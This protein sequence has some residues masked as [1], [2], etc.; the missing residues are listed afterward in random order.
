MKTLLI[1]GNGNISWH[2]VQKALEAGHEVWELNRALTRKTRRGVQPEV[3]QIIG[4]VRKNDEI[5]AMLGD[6]TFDAVCDFICYNG[7]QAA[8]DIRLFRE[9][10]KQF[11]YI[12]SEAVYMRKSS[13]LPFPETAEQYPSAVPDPYIAGK[14]QAERIF[15]SA[16]EKEG[17]P[18]TIVRPGY[19]YDT[20]V[21]SPVGQNCFTA[22]QKYISGYPL[23]MPGDGTNL[24]SPLHSRDFAEAFVPLLG[25]TGAIGEDYHITHDT[26]I[27]WNELAE[28][29]LA[30]LGTGKPRILHIPYGDALRINAFHSEIIKRQRMWHYIFDNSK[31][32]KAA[33]GW[34]AKT[35]FRDGIAETVAW[36]YGDDA[37]RRINQKYDAALEEIYG[38]FWTDRRETR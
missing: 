37:R 34:A 13:S 38:K 35:S 1:G 25:N 5:D 10:A 21:P 17:F 26:L 33:P 4:D 31:I 20:I 8:Q 3:R 23:L 32:K 2:C 22:P 30:A 19:T 7:E 24:W 36:L 11:I 29:L 16:Y 18:V 28:Q 6:E 14:I 15:G 12:S 9:R 27:T